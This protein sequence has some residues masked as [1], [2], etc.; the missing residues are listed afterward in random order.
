MAARFPREKQP[1]L[2]VHCIGTNKLCN[3]IKSN[4]T[5]PNSVQIT[6]VR[7]CRYWNVQIWIDNAMHGNL[8]CFPQ[9]KRAAVVLHYPAFCPCKVCGIVSYGDKSHNILCA[10]KACINVR[11]GGKMSGSSHTFVNRGSLVRFCFCPDSALDCTLPSSLLG[12]TDWIPSLS[13]WRHAS[14]GKRKLKL[15]VV[16]ESSPAVLVKLVDIPYHKKV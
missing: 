16:G 6:T 15:H 10:Q 12:I 8:G 14:A 1:E 3:L 7:F 4:L 2:S 5:R 11:I 9:G 13:E